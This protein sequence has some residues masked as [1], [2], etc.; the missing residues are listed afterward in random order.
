MQ[1]YFIISRNFNGLFSNCS[2]ATPSN[3][4]RRSDFAQRL[5]KITEEYIE[6]ADKKK[7]D[8]VN[9]SSNQT[10]MCA[11]VNAADTTDVTDVKSDK[12]GDKPGDVEDTKAHGDGESEK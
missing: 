6:E 5:W 10:E 3:N 7:A 4:A 8:Q 9:G 12:V 2:E 1:S 11:E